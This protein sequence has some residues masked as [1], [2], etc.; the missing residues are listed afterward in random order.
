MKGVIAWAVIS[1]GTTL[2]FNPSPLTVSRRSRVLMAAPEKSGVPIIITGNNIEVTPSLMD[3]VNEKVDRTI[4]KFAFGGSVTE[5]DVHLSVNKNPKVSEGHKA[6]VVASLKGLTIR[7]AE[8]TADMYASIDKVTDRLARKLR[9]YKERR[10]DGH[11]GGLGIGEN[12][13]AFMAET[14][15]VEDSDASDGNAQVEDEFVDP[16]EPVVTKIKS[17]DLDGAISVKEAIFALD[18]IDHDFYVFRDEETQ[19]ISV[20]YKRNAGGVGL[21]QKSKDD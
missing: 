10:N 2:S 6:E 4:G 11:H 20:V 13:A 18:Y 12:A 7:A 5:C 8:E 21:I 3:Y 1:V 19:E 16:F 17:F 14:D 9:Q 15:E